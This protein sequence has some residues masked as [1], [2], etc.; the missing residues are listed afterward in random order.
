MNLARSFVVCAVT[1]LMS[2]TPGAALPVSTTAVTGV[3]WQAQNAVYRVTWTTNDITAGRIGD[4][5]PIFSFRGFAAAGLA[6]VPRDSGVTLTRTHTVTVVSLAGSLLALRDEVF[7]D[8]RPAA[9]PSGVTRYWTIDLSRAAAP[10]FDTSGYSANPAG[11][12]DIIALTDVVPAATINAALASDAVVRK[13]VS[14][15]PA[16]LDD[17][18]AAW[19][20]GAEQQPG[21]GPGSLC[22]AVNDDV[23]TSFAIFAS[24]NGMAKV[25]LGLGGQGA[26]RANFVQIG[27]ILPLVSRAGIGSATILRPP[28]KGAPLRITDRRQ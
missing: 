6:M 2:G 26:C 8:V 24:D 20:E 1:V 25:R 16:N 3:V 5:K 12:G 23:L 14:E 27:L 4:H 11:G 10:R 9:H 19:R 17:L 28:A 21:I 22:Y 13:A 7:D 15:P 18:I